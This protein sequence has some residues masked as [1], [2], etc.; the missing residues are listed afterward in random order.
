MEMVVTTCGRDREQSNSLH[1]GAR[2]AFQRMQTGS[3]DPDPATAGPSQ[4]ARAC[5]RK[6]ISVPSQ[7]P[8]LPGFARCWIARLLLLRLACSGH[9]SA[10]RHTP[11]GRQLQDPRRS[12][13][14]C[15]SP[16]LACVNAAC[17]ASQRNNEAIQRHAG[18]C[19]RCSRL[20]RGCH[21][22]LAGAVARPRCGG[23]GRGAGGQARQ[24]QHATDDDHHQDPN[25]WRPAPWNSR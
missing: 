2:G 11:L 13:P 20:P 6:K 15:A 21:V 10:L 12:P 16:A 22:R 24:L 7:N 3:R 18:P 19:E 14:L 1:G 4:D 9:C 5:I 25:A 17:I 8:M 23:A